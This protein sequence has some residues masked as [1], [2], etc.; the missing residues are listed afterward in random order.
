MILQA[1]HKYEY[2]EGFSVA[3]KNLLNP[4]TVDSLRFFGPERQFFFE[5]LPKF[6][7]RSDILGFP[8][9]KKN[10]ILIH[11]LVKNHYIDEN[12]SEFCTKLEKW[13]SI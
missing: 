6:S 10:I 1:K 11:K 3:E 2:L 12:L 9:S 5:A 4:F 8:K 13:P 7:K